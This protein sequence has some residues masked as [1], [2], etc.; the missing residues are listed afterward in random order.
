MD[1]KLLRPLVLVIR[2]GWGFNPKPVQNEF[3]AIFLAKHPVDDRLMHHYPHILIKTCGLDVGLSSGIMGNSE[4]GHQNIGAGRVVDQEVVRIDKAIQSGDFFEN[5]VGLA[6]IEYVKK[7]QSKFHIIGLASDAAVHAKIDHLMA[8]VEFAQRA[9][10]AEV[11]IHAITDGRDSPPTSGINFVRD[12]EQRCAK[13]KIGKIATVNGRYY[14]MDR[15]RRWDR[16]Q[17]AYECMVQGIGLRFK[18]ATEALQSYY[19]APLLPSMHGDEFVPPSVIV[20]EKGQPITTIGEEDAVVFVNFRGD[21]PR[22]LTHAFV[23]PDFNGFKRSNRLELYFATMTE[24][25][26]GLPVHPFFRKPWKMQNIL[27]MYLSR[28]GLKQFRCAETEKYPHVTYFFNDY[29]DDPFDGED[30]YLVPSPKVSTYDLRPEMSAHGVCKESLRCIQSREY[31]F[32]LINFANPDMVGHTGSLPAAIRAVETVDKCVGQILDAV[33]QN[34]ASLVITADHGNCE[35]M[36]DPIHQCPHTSHT[37]NDVWF[38]IADEHHKKSKL[39]SGGRLADIA[40]TTL[41]LMGL[42]VPP[43]MTG[44][45]LLVK[46]NFRE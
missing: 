45:S 39:C 21:R 37:L 36:Y 17:R 40:P 2:D 27:G 31:D 35:Q 6:A 46:S 22:E 18:T 33:I 3:N 5:S 8:C 29:R 28:L 1:T 10:L 11:F 42:K 20:N 43:E 38:I 23:D 24:Y 7:R 4:V 19:A 9:G 14:S 41:D 26:V 16:I 12:I 44:R 30:R 25:E 13:L 15:D 34:G 32:I